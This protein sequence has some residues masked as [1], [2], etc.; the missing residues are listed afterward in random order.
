MEEDEHFSGL[1]SH[2]KHSSTSLPIFWS[3]T[4]RYQVKHISVQYKQAMIK[5][6]AAG[7][8]TQYQGVNHLISPKLD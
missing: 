2:L 1:I 8:I 7:K 4:V 3:V 5:I 6:L